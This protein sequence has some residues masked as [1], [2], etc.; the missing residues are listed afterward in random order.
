LVGNGE[1]D[2]V[3]TLNGVNIPLVQISGGRLAGNIS[4]FAG[5]TALLTFSTT[6]GVANAADF[7]YFDDIRFSIPEPSVLGLSA[8]GALLLGWRV[9]GRN[10]RVGT[11]EP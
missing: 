6:T 2:A 7:L 4:A 5:T 10:S 3:V 9:R 1:S 11:S 8:L